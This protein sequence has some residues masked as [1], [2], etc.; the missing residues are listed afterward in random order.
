LALG[1]STLTDRGRAGLRHR[2]YRIGHDLDVLA[3]LPPDYPAPRLFGST[4][5]PKSGCHTVYRH[6]YSGM[7]C[8]A[9]VAIA[10]P[11][12]EVNLQVIEGVYV[13]QAALDR[14]C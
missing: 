2:F 3:R 1:Y 5:V 12:E 10:P 4:A 8:V 7:D 13:G 6:M 11:A 14:V 9:V